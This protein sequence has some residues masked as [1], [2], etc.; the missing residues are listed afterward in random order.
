MDGRKPQVPKTLKRRKPAPVAAIGGKEIQKE[1][2][3]QDRRGRLELSDT[4]KR[5]IKQAFDLFDTGGTGRIDASELKVAL[6]ALGLTPKKEDL[7]RLT[8]DSKDGDIDFGDFLKLISFVMSEPYGRDG[9]TRDVKNAFQLLLT[10]HVACP[11]G[12]PMS[13][14]PIDENFFREPW[15]CHDCRHIYVGPLRVEFRAPDVDKG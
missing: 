14:V 12:H 10:Y 15:R 7:S 8:G 5:Q 13:Q 1:T 9:D 3:P 11:R 6:C 4:Q 2:G